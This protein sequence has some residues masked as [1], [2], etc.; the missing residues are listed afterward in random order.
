M[1]AAPLLLIARLQL[2]QLVQL[3]PVVAPLGP[4]LL[5][6]MKQAQ[7]SSLTWLAGVARIESEPT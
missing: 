4:L 6:M 2:V 1:A 5:R 3:A 7:A